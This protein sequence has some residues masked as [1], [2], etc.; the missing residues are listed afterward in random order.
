MLKRRALGIAHSSNRLIDL[1]CYE[2]DR[3]FKCDLVMVNDLFPECGISCF[4]GTDIIYLG[5]NAFCMPRMFPDIPWNKLGEDHLYISERFYHF[6]KH[7]LF[8]S[9]KY[10]C[11]LGSM[12]PLSATWSS[13]YPTALFCFDSRIA[14]ECH[15]L[16]GAFPWW[17]RVLGCP[18][19]A[20]RSNLILNE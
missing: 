1:L 10:P 9:P 3:D 7:Y 14:L 4:W 16:F 15:F 12:Y 13:F 20:L 6:F 17:A 5:I 19:K 18:A 2:V 8:K 11:H